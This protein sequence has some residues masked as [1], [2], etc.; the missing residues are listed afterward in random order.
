[1]R[2]KFRSVTCAAG[3]AAGLSLA[4]V[5]LGPSR[6][7]EGVTRKTVIE[8]ERVLV[9]AVTLES[10]ATNPMH[11]HDLP[12]VIVVLEGAR[13]EHRLPDGSRYTREPKAGDT[14]WRDAGFEHAETNVG[15]TRM[16]AVLVQLKP[17]AV[18]P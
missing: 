11:R 16:R 8:N 17:P 7:D 5:A 2:W 10:G 1:M 14:T 9:T 4:L 12:A 13:I 18:T 3:F 6:A 15:T